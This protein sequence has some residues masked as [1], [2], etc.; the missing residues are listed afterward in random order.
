MKVLENNNFIEVTC[1]HCHSKLG[2]HLADIRYHEIAHRTPPFTASC[3][4]C[5][6]TVGVPEASIPRSWVAALV[7][8]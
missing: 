1:S 2:V 3:G 6:G 8:E 5:G 7:D 4:A